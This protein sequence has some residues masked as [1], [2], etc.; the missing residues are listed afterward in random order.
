MK[1]VSKS[2]LAEAAGVSYKTF[3]RW[4]V[5]NDDRLTALGYERSCKL[6]PPSV[7]AFICREYDIDEEELR[8]IA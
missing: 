2:Q 1:Y 6:V 7:V 5:R 8:G 3:Q 4:L